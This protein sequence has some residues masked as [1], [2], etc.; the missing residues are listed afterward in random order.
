MALCHTMSKPDSASP[1]TNELEEGLGIRGQVRAT[2]RALRTSW[3]YLAAMMV[4]LAVL[5]AGVHT[6]TIAAP[7]LAEQERSA[8][9]AEAA[10]ERAIVP[11]PAA[12][13]GFPIPALV[14]GIVLAFAVGLAG[15]QVHR[16]R[17]TAHRIQAARARPAPTAAAAA[18]VAPARPAP[19]PPEPAAPPPRPVTI[20]PP[21]PA[22][23]PPPPEADEAERAEAERERVETERAE[24][25]R[26]EAARLETERLEAERAEAERL[27]AERAEAERREAARAAAARREAERAARLDAERHEAERLEA[28]RREATRAAA[29]RDEQNRLHVAPEVPAD[30]APAT[31]RAADAPLTN[32]PEAVARPRPR[33]P[34]ERTAPPARRFVPARQWPDEATDLWT[35]EIAWK[36]GYLK[37]TFRAMAGP[38]GGN[39]RMLLGESPSLKWTLMTDPEPPT[40]EMIA[41]VRSL[42]GALAAAGWE[43]TT[44]GPAWYEQRFLWRGD[45]EPK[46]V[47]VPDSVESRER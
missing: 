29:R 19:A 36:A 37:S 25:L 24:T 21:P 40:P 30:E 8:Q 31:P 27:E 6:M 44:P 47:T 42:I 12:T 34:A 2:I 15:G 46:P 38:P 28:E 9:G 13:E 4:T 35:C 22:A 41:G 10:A 5:A 43:R 3:W 23:P 33:P 26:A 11:R 17:R 20:V 7:A 16:R 45:G 14:G 1:P 39:R 18:P 32:A